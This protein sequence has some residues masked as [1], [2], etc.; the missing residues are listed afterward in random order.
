MRYFAC[1][2]YHVGYITAACGASGPHGPAVPC[3]CA[4]R[5]GYGRKSHFA[6]E[7]IPDNRTAYTLPHSGAMVPRCHRNAYERRI[8][9]HQRCWG[10]QGHALLTA[11]RSHIPLHKAGARECLASVPAPLS[12]AGVARFVAHECCGDSGAPLPCCAAMYRQFCCLE[13]T[14]SQHMIFGHT[15]SGARN[16]RAQRG[17]ADRWLRKQPWYNIHD[18]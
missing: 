9:Q 18:T 11:N 8:E 3:G 5:C 6:M 2:M 4:L 12:S 7:L 14:P 17:H 15:H 16:H 10:A 13:S 1:V